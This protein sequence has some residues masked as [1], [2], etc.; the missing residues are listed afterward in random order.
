[1][2]HGVPNNPDSKCLSMVFVL[3]WGAFLGESSSEYLLSK[4][5]FPRFPFLRLKNPFPSSSWAKEDQFPLTTHSSWTDTQTSSHLFPALTKESRYTDVICD[6][7][8]TH[9]FPMQHLSMCDSA[10]EKSMRPPDLTPDFRHQLKLSNLALA[11]S[12]V[13]FSTE[14]IQESEPSCPDPDLSAHGLYLASG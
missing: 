4:T 14:K 11:T 10:Y 9:C 3:C 6:P 2:V 8:I 1:M 7:R 12:H 13:T 5:T